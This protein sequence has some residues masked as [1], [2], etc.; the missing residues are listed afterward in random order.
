M[1]RNRSRILLRRSVGLAFVLVCMLN[2]AGW[3]EGLRFSRSYSDN[4]VLQR[5][6]PITI[7]GF[8]QKG[9]EITVSFA[10]QHKTVTAD[11]AG[12]WSVVLDAMPARSKGA[13]L[14]A[15]AAGAKVTLKDVVVGDVILFARQTSIDVS[16]GRDKQ[17]QDDAAKLPADSRFRV[18]RIATAPA[19]APQADLAPQATDGWMR[20]DKASALRMSAAAFYVGRDLAAEVDVPVGIIDLNMG[21][22]FPIAWMSLDA[23]AEST[24]VFGEDGS[25]VDGMVDRMKRETAEF[26]SGAAQKALDAHYEKA[27]ELAKGRGQPAPEKPAPLRHPVYNPLFPAAGYN[28]VLHP[29]KSLTL[30]GILLQLGN[31]YPY[32]LYEELVR[33]GESTR[34]GRLG[35]AYKDT[36][37]RR[38]WCVK[39]EPYTIPR[40]PNQWRQTFSDPALPIGWMTPPGSDLITLGR[41]HCEM[42]ELQRHVADQTHGVQLILPGME[43][44]PFSAQPADEA[45][46][47]SRCM[48]WVL[49]ALYG[50]KNV[51]PT[52][53]VFQR[54]AADYARATL[55][56]TPGTA[57]GLSA[58]PGALDCFEVAAADGVFVPAEAAI[59]GQTIRLQTDK[60]NRIAHVRYNW[61][62]RPNQGLTNAAGLPMV[63]FRTDDH[64]YPGVINTLGEEDLPAEFSTPVTEWKSKGAVIVNGGLDKRI[65]RNAGRALGSTGLRVGFFGPNLYVNFALKGSPADGKIK[66]GDLIYSVNGATFGDEPLRDVAEAITRAESEAGQGKITFGVH[67]DGRNADVQLDLEVLGTYSST[68]PFD[69]PKTDRIVANAEAFLAE[70]GGVMPGKHPAFQFADALLLLGAGSPEYQGLVRRYVYARMAGWDPAERIDPVNRQGIIQPWGPSAEALLVGEYYLATGDK[71][72]LPF[73]KHCCDRLGATQL[74]YAT[75]PTPWPSALKG[76]VGGWRHN[77]YGGQT[78]GTMPCVG[79]PATLGFMFAKEAGVEYDLAIY[80]RAVKWFIHNGVKVGKVGYGFH[81]EPVTTPMTIDPDK[82]KSGMFFTNNGAISGGA[83]LFD[84]LGDASTSHRCSFLSVY[85]YN[86]THE[87]HGG[88]FWN[89]FWTPLGARVHGAKSFQTFMKGNRWYQELQRMYFHGRDQGNA[90]MGAGQ[91]LALV[92]PRERLRILGAP[93]SVFAANPPETLRPAID[94]YHARDY[95]GCD[96][97]VDAL[98]QTGVLIGEDLRK[99]RQLK[100]ASQLL[101]QSIAHDLAKVRGLIADGKFYEASLDV[102]QLSGVVGPGN[103]ELAAILQALRSPDAHA[104]LAEDK[105]RYDAHIKALAFDRLIPETPAEDKGAWQLLTTQSTDAHY[106]VGQVPQAQATPWRLKVVESLAQAPQEWTTSNFEDTS[107]TPTTLPISWHLNHI[108]LL[109]APFEIKD[110]DA[111]KALRIRNWTFRQQD[112][113]IYI[114]GTA[115][116]KISNAAAESSL[117]IPLN[118]AAVNALRNGRNTIAATYKNNWRWGRYTRQIELDGNNSVYNGGVT[119]LLEMHADRGQ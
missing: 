106:P 94:A 83:V 42:R 63:P 24:E 54:M 84:L 85:A 62:H 6:K 31:D 28:A 36:Y 108:A 91:F 18:M 103:A 76:Q 60:I 9:S 25:L 70:R 109:R 15:T 101:R 48:H 104:R 58:A 5:N 14:V 8:S 13:D 46:V 75:R 56:F 100:A 16:L 38:K 34:R 21:P 59:D 4:A 71:N 43:H 3:A 33:E 105:K 68:S 26:E 57:E 55:H 67:R 2:A 72:V 64:E 27:V 116:A 12:A 49:G 102:P 66:A 111:V 119:L 10:G 113:V 86:N 99:A 20:V 17:G 51:T 74:K 117:T 30:K 7:T 65:D 50:Q 41:H 22:A 97:K 73:L 77:L 110:K 87:G 19:V 79:I 32:V 115:V 93:P 53:P 96:A 1:T 89:N 37:D 45:L 82:L 40:I 78:Y 23:L 11:E 29:L 52:G 35:L 61:R 39:L 44:I 47:A 114:N 118:E 98:I 88:N 107:W 92:A 95:S 80:D 90:G 69:C 81:A 112:M